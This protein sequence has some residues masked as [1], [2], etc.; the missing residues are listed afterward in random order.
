M[1]LMILD[2]PVK[3]REMLDTGGLIYTR[4]KYGTNSIV[5]LAYLIGR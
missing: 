5:S 4:K 2:T 1:E 3:L